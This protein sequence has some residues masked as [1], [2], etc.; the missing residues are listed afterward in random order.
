MSRLG[1]FQTSKEFLVPCD[2]EMLQRS[3]LVTAADGSGWA[4]AEVLMVNVLVSP[5]SQMAFNLSSAS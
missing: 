3:E 5:N 1:N 4:L 2:E